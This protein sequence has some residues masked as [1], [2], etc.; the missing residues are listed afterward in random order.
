MT[1]PASYALGATVYVVCE[2]SSDESRPSQYLTMHEQ[3]YTIDVGTV[4]EIRLP[5]AAYPY[6]VD[7]EEGDDVWE[8]RVESRMVHAT[9]K[10][11]EKAAKAAVGEM[12]LRLAT[13]H[14]PVIVSWALVAL[15]T[16]DSACVLEDLAYRNRTLMAAMFL[17][18][19]KKL[20]GW[21]PAVRSFWKASE[22]SRK[23][24]LT[25]VK[26]MLDAMAANHGCS[27]VELP[28][29]LA[30][31]NTPEFDAVGLTHVLKLLYPC[32]P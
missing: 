20:D 27:V 6:T 10:A 19:A 9:R 2:A 21:V 1:A 26:P 23:N 5:T 16:E 14:L 30:K 15:S 17:A 29:V 25:S 32:L 28:A 22:F 12:R 31:G 4:S 24:V 18:G 13:A 8:V 3:P 11:A 7:V